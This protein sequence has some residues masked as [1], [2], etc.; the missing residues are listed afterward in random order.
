MK[1]VLFF[2]F[3]PF[4]CAAQGVKLA[5]YDAFLKKQRIEMEPVTLLSSSTKL[6][7]TFFGWCRIF[8]LM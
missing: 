3:L 2:L 6:T 5:Q 8:L 1:R 7:L 4:A